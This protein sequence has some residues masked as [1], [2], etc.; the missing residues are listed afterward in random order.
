MKQKIFIYSLLLSL[1]IGFQSCD[2]DDDVIYFDHS[3][4]TED[5][6][7]MIA[8][9]LSYG[10]YGLVSVMNQISNEIQEI[11]ECDSVY[12]YNDTIRGETGSGNIS[13]EY[14]YNEIYELNC[15]ADDGALFNSTA[16][17]TFDSPYYSYDHDLVIDF[18]VTGLKEESESEIFNGT[19]KRTGWWEQGYYNQDYYFDFECTISNAAV[20]KASNKIYSGTSEF[21][22]VESYHFANLEFTYKGTVEFINED[23]AKV[24][25]DSGD[26]FYVDLNNVSLAD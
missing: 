10:S 8:L 7:K 5:A 1:F 22:L 14:I 17:Q 11:S 24:I 15:E 18:D 13:Y 26:I 20:S 19:Y 12:Q 21:V 25:F 3:H 4:A 16:T 2:D 6:E 23:E 9:S